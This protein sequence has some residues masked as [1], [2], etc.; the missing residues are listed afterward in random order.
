MPGTSTA[1][2]DES[3]EEAITPRLG[4][5]KTTTKMMRR[6]TLGRMRNE[7][8]IEAGLPRGWSGSLKKR[9]VSRRV[10]RHRLNCSADRQRAADSSNT[11]V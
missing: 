1:E 10:L 6:P 9:I 7:P 2:G 11:C 8:R 5:P 4:K 3:E